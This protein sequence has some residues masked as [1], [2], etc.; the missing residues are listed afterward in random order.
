MRQRLTS[1]ALALFIA[2]TSFLPA[3]AA[4]PSNVSWTTEIEKTSDT[5][6]IIRWIADIKEGWH[7]YGLAMPE[8]SA[9]PTSFDITPVDGLTLIGDVEAS[10]EIE[11]HYDEIGRASCRERV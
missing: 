10:V 11:N 5:E 3:T 4:L 1:L 6:G 8:G 2:I 9:P 7:I